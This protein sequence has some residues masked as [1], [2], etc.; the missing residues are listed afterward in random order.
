MPVFDTSITTSDASIDRVLAQPL[1]VLLYLFDKPDLPHQPILDRLARQHAGSLLVVRLNAAENPDAY[2][3]QPP[4]PA[5]RHRL[6]RGQVKSQGSASEV[7]AHANYLLGRGP[8]PIEKSTPPRPDGRLHQASAASGMSVQVTDATF[9]AEVLQSDIPVLVDFW[10]PWCGPCHMVAPT[11]DR[12]AQQ[13]VGRIKVA[14]LNVDENGQTPARYQISGI[15]HLIM[16]KN[17]ALVGRLV[18]AHPQQNIEALIQ[19]ALL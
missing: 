10:A 15:P 9:A 14:K 3:L 17:G 7:E 4:C 1:P 2:A 13:Y 18:G 8:R 16:F 11:L 5:C 12:L 19:K 6:C